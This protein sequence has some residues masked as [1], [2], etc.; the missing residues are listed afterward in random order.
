MSYLKELD[1]TRIEVEE[2]RRIITFS[3]IHAD[4]HSLIIAL[5]DCAQVI[6]K[7]EGHKF[8]I[9]SEY[10]PELE[11]LLNIELISKIQEDYPD[12]LNYEWIGDTC[13]IVIVG[14]II[15]G[16]RNNIE[17]KPCN[18]EMCEDHEYPQI[19]LK[20]LK[21]INALNKQAINKGGK[22]F[23]L[24]GNHE[25]M[26]FL[27]DFTYVFANDMVSANYFNGISRQQIF[28]IG[29][30]GYELLFEDSCRALLMINNYIFVHGQL[31][32]KIDDKDLDFNYFNDINNNLINQTNLQNTFDELIKGDNDITNFLNGN[33]Q[34][35]ARTY[36]Y[37]S[38]IEKRNR[39]PLDKD[40]F[41]N[42]I[43]N[44]DFET[45]LKGST[46]KYNA[47][48]L[49]IIIGHC[50]QSDLVI[51]GISATSLTKIEEENNIRQILVSPSKTGNFDSKE[52]LIFGITMECAHSNG[53]DQYKIYKVDVGSS[54][55]FDTQ[56]PF[57][58]IGDKEKTFNKE[59]EIKRYFSRTPQV[60]EL[61][62]DNAKIIKS[63]IKNTRIHQPRYILEKSIKDYKLKDLY[64]DIKPKSDN[65]KQNINT[66]L[67]KY[68]IS[69]IT[70]IMFSV[71]IVNFI[72]EL[73]KNKSK[74]DN[75]KL[76]TKTIIIGFG[77]I[78]FE[79]IFNNTNIYSTFR[80]TI[81]KFFTNLFKTFKSNLKGGQINI[82]PKE[83]QN[84]TDNSIMNYLIN[85]FTTIFT[86]LIN[87]NNHTKENLLLIINS[88]FYEENIS[89]KQYIYQS[90]ED[91]EIDITNSIYYKEFNKLKQNNINLSSNINNKILSI[92]NKIELIKKSIDKEYKTI[93]E[94]NNIISGLRYNNL[95]TFNDNINF[96]NKNLNYNTMSEYINNYKKLIK[97]ENKNIKYFKTIYY[98]I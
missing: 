33:S 16:H 84:N 26:N 3:D 1:V 90:E 20:I 98:N 47:N 71:V 52:N 78:L 15:D 8:D 89:D 79:I 37:Y 36:G 83:K 69:N 17:T 11:Q 2:S 74:E 77:T 27:H 39:D 40:N 46:S 85:L 60:L 59:W 42:K 54:R 35:W 75:K 93:I 50:V 32:S 96:S 91:E 12:D 73:L 10:D 65:I 29:N 56:H 61:I 62:N 25:V 18:G 31:I 80:K 63:Q 19:E 5:R 76:I 81:D 66:F 58:I 43:V 34:L 48:Q 45:F 68:N 88:E 72:Y 51:R 67:N 38:N 86:K 41:C 44:H 64:L 28:D 14:D 55:A 95:N 82:N 21:F 9:E 13:I 30:Y 53:N 7:K 49:K 87:S 24:L 97:D 57:S 23:K 6:Q 70:I 22:I 92:I 94:Y 4:I